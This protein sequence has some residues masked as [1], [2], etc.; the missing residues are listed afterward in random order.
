MF[1]EHAERF[2]HLESLFVGDMES[3]ECEI[4]WIQQ[5]DYSRLYAAL[6]NLK[7]LTIKGTQGWN[8]E[9]SPTTNWNIWKSSLAVRHVA[10]SRHCK[11]LNCLR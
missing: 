4:S 6:P 9:K 11:T 2:A 7:K 10:C 5:G 3:E 8:W 1:V